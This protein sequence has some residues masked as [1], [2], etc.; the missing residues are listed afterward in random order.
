MRIIGANV[1]IISDSRGNETLEAGLRSDNFFASASIPAGKSTGTHEAFVLEPQKAIE[2]FEEIKS[3]ILKKEC[4]TQEDFDKFLIALDGTENKENLG[5]N[6]ILSLSLAWARL[7]AKENN[8]ELFEYINKI[9]SEIF[10]GSAI[11]KA[12]KPIFNVI[13]GGAH[14]KN[15]LDFQEFQ[16]IPT[17]E[18]FNIAYSVGREYYRKLK[19]VLDDKFGEENITL[20]DEAGYSA[21]FKTNEEALEIMADLIA[22][23]KYPLR[24]GLDVAASQYYRAEEYVIN[25]KSY[26]KEEI[27]EYYLKLIEAYDI[28]SIEDPFYEEDFDSFASLTADL[29]GLKT[30]INADNISKNWENISSKPDVLVITDDLT[31]TNS[32]RLKMAVDKNSGNAILVKLNQIGSLTET[33]EVVKMAYDNNWQVVVSHRSG[34]TMDDFIADLAVGVGAWGL[35]SGAP[36]KP[37]RLVKYERVLKIFG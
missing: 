34:E 23:N 3:E 30:R 8:Q 36:G 37:E 24:I 31:T 33:L 26:S 10:F 2:K 35:K 9:F 6:L 27:K 19:K 25:K 29:R 18:D 4:R 5:G 22:K 21:L 11:I 17:T 32:K 7:R 1:K 28:L 20:G 13:N 14:A 15:K 16:V 12:P